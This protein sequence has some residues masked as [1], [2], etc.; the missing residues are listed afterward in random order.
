MLLLAFTL[1]IVA[2]ISFFIVISITRNN[3]KVVMD[4]SEIRGF[5]NDKLWTS[6]VLVS[7]RARW[8][9]S[10]LARVR[11]QAGVDAQFEL[12]EGLA[13]IFITSRYAG[14]FSSLA[15]QF[16]VRDI[17][18]LFSKRIQ[19]V[20]TDLVYDSLPLS[21]LKP[22]PRSRPLPLALGERSGKSPGSSLE[23]YSIEQYQ[24]FTET[25]N[26]LWK[27]V[28]RMPD[29]SLIV[30]IRDS[31][32]PKVVR[33]GF[34]QIA[35]RRDLRAKLEFIDLACEAIGMMGNSLLA[36]GTTVEIYYASKTEA[37]GSVSISEISTLEQLADALME[38]SESP[39]L[40]FDSPS[41]FKILDQSDILV[42]GARDLEL[43]TLALPV[44]KLVTLVIAESDSSPS[45]VG[46]K[47][48]MYTGI[49]DVR[50]L[51]S[52]VLEK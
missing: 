23:L 41:A 5:K 2:L 52:K 6:A 36:T 31:S 38:L 1:S 20:Y 18:N 37:E 33:I 46:Q 11:S 14:R 49:E 25:K 21:I 22:L 28:A 39:T 19:T 47:A 50:K 32:I 43:R 42:C 48:M 24:P 17:L 16:E 9:N 8:V 27:K 10:K 7:R 13:R 4:P 40:K 45:I 51:V 3:T 15:L 34:I 26:I 30:R 44:S 35:E 12:S 29:E